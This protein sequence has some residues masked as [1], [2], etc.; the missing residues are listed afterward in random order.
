MEIIWGVT[1]VGAPGLFFLGLGLMTV[2]G[3]PPLFARLCF[4]A[5]CAWAAIVGFRWLV[6]TPAS[7]GW[8]VAAGLALGAFVFVLVPQ[9]VRLTYAQTPPSQGGSMT[10]GSAPPPINAPGNQGIITQGQTG[11]TNIINQA[12]PH[13]HITPEQA[14]AIVSSV[15]GS[16]ISVLLTSPDD[17][18]VRGYESEIARALRAGGVAVQFFNIGTMQPPP[19]GVEVRPNGHE[20]KVLIAALN[21]GG[22]TPTIQDVPLPV[23][24]SVKQ[25]YSQYI[26]L[27]VGFRQD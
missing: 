19:R 13:R 6:T 12:P 2:L 17:I 4:V 20:T 11:G 7:G 10:N 3:S 8:R 5:S 18:E 25:Q 24:M 27:V 23:P 16:G 14:S 26:G 1:A 9:M 15:E 22:I 21:N